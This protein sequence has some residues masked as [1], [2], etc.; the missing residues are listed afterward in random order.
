MKKIL[1]AVLFCLSS[2]YGMQYDAHF[3]AGVGGGVQLERF[4]DESG[5]KNTPNFASLKVGY[6][7][8]RA[9]SIELMLNYVDNESKIFSPDDGARYGIDIA[10]VKAFDFTSLFYPSIRAGFGASEMKVHRQLEDKI[11]SSS[12]NVGGGILI[13]FSKHFEIELNYDYKYT[14]YGAI[15]LVSQKKR[16]Y[17]HINQFYLGFNTRF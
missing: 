13:P 5:A 8:K 9:Y 3:Y 15:D 2:L 7:D 4:T 17:S 6:G 11:A 16:L 1:L 14:S 10:F 12:F